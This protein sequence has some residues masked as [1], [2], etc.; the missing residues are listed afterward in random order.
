LHFEGSARSTVAERVIAQ[1]EGRRTRGS[2]M[3][4]L[5]LI[6]IA[7]PRIKEGLR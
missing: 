2:P 1:E 6:L 4:R 7:G 3:A 5:M